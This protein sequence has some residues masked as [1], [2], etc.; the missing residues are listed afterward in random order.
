[1][2][3]SIEARV[4]VQTNEPNRCHCPILLSNPFPRKISILT[5]LTL[6]LRVTLSADRSAVDPV[7]QEIMAGRRQMKE[8]STGKTMPSSYPLQEALAKMP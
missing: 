1:M 5:R 8:T 4:E 2:L 7:V 3:E 6:V